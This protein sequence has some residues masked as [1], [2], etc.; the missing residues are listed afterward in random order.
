M[1]EY[2]NPEIDKTSWLPGPWTD[3]PDKIQWVDSDTNLDCLIVRNTN[4][5]LC[6]YVGVEESHPF[7]QAHHRSIYQ[8]NIVVHGGVNFSSLCQQGWKL[9]SQGVCHIPEPGRPDTVWWFGFD[10]GHIADVIP[11][12]YSY[13]QPNLLFCPVYRDVDYVKN[14]C[15]A[16][17]AQLFTYSDSKND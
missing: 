1:K 13:S 8:E 3:E 11:K 14:Q 7:F 9:P 16:L 17:A 10:C 2:F 5:V 15:K 12:D 4:G 6:G